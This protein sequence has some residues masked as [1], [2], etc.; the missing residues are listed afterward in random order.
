MSK[1][2]EEKFDLI[3]A[4][5]KCGNKNYTL[6]CGTERRSYCNETGSTVTDKWFTRPIISSLNSGYGIDVSPDA[7]ADYAGDGEGRMHSCPKCGR[8]RHRSDEGPR[9]VQYL[10]ANVRQAVWE[11]AILDIERKAAVKAS[12]GK[13][14]VGKG[15]H[16][17]L[18]ESIKSMGLA[19]D[20]CCK[21]GTQ[22]GH[23]YVRYTFDEHTDEPKVEGKFEVSVHMAL[24]EAQAIQLAAMIAKL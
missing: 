3:L 4:C 5:T 17:F 14:L 12:E 20:A 1:G 22:R 15:L 10:I 18:T 19:G 24:T 21:Y 16:T 2:N 9:K 7:I 6:G 8:K 11:E 13:D 23:A